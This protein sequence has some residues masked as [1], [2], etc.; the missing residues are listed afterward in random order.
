MAFGVVMVLLPAEVGDL[1][2]GAS[3]NPSL[4]LRPPLPRQLLGLRYLRGGHLR[5]N[6]IAVEDRV[7]AVLAG[8]GS[9][10]GKVIP[11]MRLDV[12]LGDA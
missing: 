7:I 9:R 11:H 6:N 1:S 3:R 4:L 12:V 2:D 8:G 10:S 5:S